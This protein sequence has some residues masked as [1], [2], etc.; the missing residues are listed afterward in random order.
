MKR[1]CSF[2]YKLYL[3]IS[4][5]DC[6]GR[7]F[8][9]VA[10]QAILGGVD[11]IQVREKKDDIDTFI[12]KARQLKEMTDKYRIPLIINDNLEVAKK[13]DSVGIHVGNNDVPPVEIRKQWDDTKYVGYSI[14]FL[15]QLEN[16]QA[17]V[18]DYLGISP[19]F[20]TPTKTDTVTEWGLE[21]V[22]EIRRLTDKPLVAIGN[23]HLYNV[24]SVVHAGADC[25]AVVS[26]ICGATNPQKAAYELK[27]EILR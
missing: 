8:L 26:E 11:I 19:V 3:V 20:S 16:E 21:G 18:S 5:S 24:K 23:I 14:E 7:N 9:E 13:V 1:Q 4:E 12:R 17:A 27:N 15:E 10:E 25:I 22:A 2:P 6:K